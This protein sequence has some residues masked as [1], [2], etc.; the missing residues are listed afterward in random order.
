MARTIMVR[1]PVAICMTADAVTT[2][3]TRRHVAARLNV[4]LAIT[5]A[6]ALNFLL[7]GYQFGESNH[8]VYLLDALHRT[9]PELLSRD[10]F[11]TQTFQYH[12]LFGYV[13]RGLMRIG[14]LE[15]GFLIGYLVL[16]IALHVAWWR[17][18]AALGGGVRTFLTSQLLGAGTALGMYQILQDSSFLPSNIAAVAMLWGIAMWLENRRIASGVALGVASAFHL[19]YALVGLLLWTLL[20]ACTMHRARRCSHKTMWTSSAFAL[21]PALINIGFALRVTSRRNSGLPLAEFVDLYVRLRHPHHYDPSSWPAWLWLS[22]ALPIFPA[23]IV[24]VRRARNKTIDYAWE[25]AGRIFF[26]LGGIIVVA[27]IAAGLTYTSEQIVQ[28]SLF[29]FSVFLKVLSCVGAAI[30]FDGL[31]SALKW[32]RAEV[33]TTMVLGLLLMLACLRDGPYLGLFEI[34]YD[35]PQ[36]NAMCDWARQHTPANAI[37]IVPPNEQ[38]FRLRAERA[39]V[40]N[41]KAV[42]Q[43]SGELPQWR[44]RL[45]DVLDLRNLSSI[46]REDFAAA[47]RYIRDRY[48]TLPPERFIAVAKKY[49]ARYVLTPKPWPNPYEPLRVGSDENRFWFMYDLSRLN[50][51]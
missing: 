50:H 11:T 19:N 37:F 29:R 7:Q 31:T 17:I 51:P 2:P 26:M 35:D 8:T 24:W 9:H 10:W 3:I 34:A 38:D 49:N 48:D 28:A 33:I 30:L 42:P 44:D 4:A 23:V 45:Q 15:H 13:T 21:I 36:Y 14:F 20:H 25:Q 41:F 40:V 43:L 5:F 12:A 16:L 6:I 27:L 39:I 46:P 18:V 22:F 32:E 1:M 47:L